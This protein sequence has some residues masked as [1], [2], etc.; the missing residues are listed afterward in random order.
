MQNQRNLKQYLRFLKHSHAAFR[1]FGVTSFQQKIKVFP[2]IR[3]A[4]FDYAWEP[5]EYYQFNFEG[6]SKEEIESYVATKEH[7]KMVYFFNPTNE[8]TFLQDKWKTYTR[9]KDFFKREVLFVT[10]ST[11]DSW[12]QFISSHESI[13]LKPVD[14]TFGQGVRIIKCSDYI[15]N[16]ERIIE[17]YPSGVLAE[18]LILQHDEFSK[19]HPESVNTIRIYSICYGNDVVVFHPWL[20]IGKGKSVID[21]ASAGGIG[22]ALDGSTGRIIS[23]GDKSGH[24]YESHPDTHVPLIDYKIPYYEELI[25]TV[26]RLALVNNKLHYAGWDMALSKDGWELVEGN[27]RAQIGFQ[28]ME[29]HGFRDDLNTFLERFGVKED[30]YKYIK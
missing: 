30:Y 18:E 19:L 23:A 1:K 26:K 22:A 27:P 29:Q 7:I 14:G 15:N 3:K 5:F 4:Y 21:N 28:I 13:I 9:Y 8:I 11:I 10:E 12:K 24:R 6:K 17:E 20:R 25:E 2:K 16:P